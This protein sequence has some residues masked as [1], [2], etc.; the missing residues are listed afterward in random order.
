MGRSNTETAVK[1][2]VVNRITF[3]GNRIA[4]VSRVGRLSAQR[5][6]GL[7]G[8]AGLGVADRCSP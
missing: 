4:Q 8:R 5:G 2:T 3:D 1:D 7:A 6:G